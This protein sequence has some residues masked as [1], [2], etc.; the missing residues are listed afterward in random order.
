MFDVRRDGAPLPALRTRK[1]QWLLAL[2]VLKGAIPV[3]RAWLAGTLWP[4]TTEENAFTSL[5]KSLNDLRNALGEE[6]YRLYAPTSRTL[7]FDLSDVFCDLTR[8][9]ASV[10]KSDEAVLEQAVALYRGALLEDCSEEWVVLERAEREQV[11]LHARETLAV[12]AVERGD[13]STAIEHL[14]PCIVL[15][16]L[17]ESAQRRLMQAFAAVGNYAAATQT[18]RDLRLY[19]HRE[20]SI[21][22]DPETTRLYEQLRSEAQNSAR[23]AVVSSAP[24]KEIR[25]PKETGRLS[26]IPQPMTELVGRVREIV[27]IEN[28]LTCARLV[29]VTGTGGVGKTRLAT[30]VA[31]RCVSRYADGAC[32]VELAALTEP[33]L[34][35]QTVAALLGVREQPDQ[36]AEESLLQYL[37]TREVLLVLDNCE[38]LIQECRRL[39]GELLRHCPD[40]SL[41]VTTRQAL[42]ITGET[43]WVV[44]SLS[45]PDPEPQVREK[46]LPSQ[47][48]EFDAVRLFVRRAEQVQ[49]AFRLTTKNAPAVRQICRQLDGI[50]LAIEL[51]AA[52]LRVLT[53]EQIAL[54]L[55]DRFHLLTGGSQTAQPRQ[56]TLKSALDWSYELL[57]EGERSLLRSLAV[58][59][60]GWTLEA[61]EAVC[62]EGDALRAWEVLD[63]LTSLL[64]KSLVIFKPGDESEGRYYLLET[65]RHYGLDRLVEAGEAETVR[66]RH[67]DTYL[68]MMEALHLNLQG[69]EQAECLDRIEG[70]HDNVRAALQFCLEQRR[71]Q[72]TTSGMQK[73]EEAYLRLV[74][75]MTDFWERRCYW[76]EG[77]AHLAEALEVTEGI[78]PRLRT[79]VL[80]AVAGMRKLQGDP[81]GARRMNEQGLVLARAQ[82]NSPQIATALQQ[83]G[84]LAMIEGRYAEAEAYFEE[85]LALSRAGNNRRGVAVCLTNLATITQPAGDYP[86]SYCLLHESLGILRELDDRAKIGVV[87]NNLGNLYYCQGNYAEARTYYEESLEIRRELGSKHGIALVLMHL[88]NVCN[89]LGEY[90]RARQLM[91]ESLSIRRK[92]GEVQQIGYALHNLGNVAFRRGDYAVAAALHRE[93]IPFL[94]QAMDRPAL[95]TVLEAFATLAETDGKTGCAVRIWAASTALREQLGIPQ[96]PAANSEYEGRLASIRKDVGD[97]SFEAEWR[98]GS[99]LTLEQALEYAQG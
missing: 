42:G 3:D 32:F 80:L 85:A 26:F 9:D 93:C 95:T 28:A 44:P 36:S 45:L 56:Q 46:D 74:C 92:M 63:L 97:A 5:R 54:R 57:T 7:T 8:F 48:M 34:V 18:Y 60:G 30:E 68:E 73:A 77:A 75:S 88:G 66:A 23:H 98:V 6:A 17:R 43:V 90:D 47:L 12:M 22:P 51:A 67:R 24:P 2:L 14:R 84:T 38:H 91:E 70:E 21:E 16:P 61:A 94:R 55:E 62:R 89:E 52:R 25:K 64:D 33:K 87:L 50:P 83:L 78:A 13:H 19:L 11:Y 35:A 49:P 15:D 39:S 4:D 99:T 59:A 81:V 40:L 82:Q 41:L 58:F 96:T 1:G 65:V 37:R 79:R 72:A 53:P 27:E 71:A 69:P 31:Q 20:L 86:R 76:S 29:A 10:A